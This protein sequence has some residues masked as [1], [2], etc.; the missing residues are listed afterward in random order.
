MLPVLLSGWMAFSELSE[1]GG[2]KNNVVE[3]VTLGHCCRY[4]RWL[5]NTDD[6]VG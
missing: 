2:V 3:D 6:G 1:V 4:V 5:L